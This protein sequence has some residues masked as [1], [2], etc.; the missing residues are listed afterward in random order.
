MRRIETVAMGTTTDL[1]RRGA[2]A[3]FAGAG[4]VAATGWGTPVRAATPVRFQ[5]NW[6]AEAEHG[7]FYQAQATGL[8]A[9]AG[10]DVTLMQG[11]P[12]VNGAQLLAGGDTDLMMG[13][14]MQTLAN[15]EKGVPMV[16]VASSFQFELQC[17]VA[18]PNITSL[19]DLRGHTILISSASRTTFWPWLAARYGYSDDQ[20]QPY[21]YSYQ[22]FID[23]ASVAQQGFITYDDYALKKA[24]VAAKLFLL[25]DEGYPTYGSTIVTTRA[26]LASNRSVVERFV[27]ASLE[28]WK[29][30]LRDPAPGNALILNANPKMTTGQI[31]AT[32]DKLRAVHALDRGDA[33]RLGI[34]CMTDARWRATRDLMVRSKLLDAGTD[35]RAAYTTDI[36]NRLHVMA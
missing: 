9:R 19:A 12:Q 31:A 29:S 3:A 24:G 35:W 33:A 11:S 8:Y 10:L 30:Y 4:V 36:C 16:A 14:D 15:V 17:I 2:L 6:F 20:A 28:G 32:V 18:H 25:A 1:S 7:G 13:F 21:S 26:Y 5:T 22:R 27:R 34:G 23:D